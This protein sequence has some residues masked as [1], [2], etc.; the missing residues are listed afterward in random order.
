MLM[1]INGKIIVC[2][3]CDEQEIKAHAGRGKEHDFLFLC[4]HGGR[5]IVED[6]DCLS[7]YGGAIIGV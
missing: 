7:L 6:D 1:S 5:L 3:E 4:G 2:S